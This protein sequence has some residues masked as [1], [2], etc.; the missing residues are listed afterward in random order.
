M[1]GTPPG[2]PSGGVPVSWVWTVALA[3]VAADV[4]LLVAGGDDVRQAARG[5]LRTLAFAGC[6]HWIARINP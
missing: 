2:R 1:T 5:I 6:L 3:W 4:L